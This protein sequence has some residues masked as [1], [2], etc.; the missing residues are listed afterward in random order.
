MMDSTSQRTVWGPS[1]SKFWTFKVKIRTFRKLVILYSQFTLCSPE[2]GPLSEHS[3]RTWPPCYEV[4]KCINEGVSVQWR[5]HFNVN[6][7]Y[8]QVD[9]DY[10]IPLHYTPP[11]LK[12]KWSK[13]SCSNPSKQGFILSNSFDRLVCHLLGHLLVGLV[14]LESRKQCKDCSVQFNTFIRQE[15]SQQNNILM[16]PN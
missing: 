10:A 3:S 12:F 7:T 13:I 8:G 5:C 15:V 1:S 14:D 4:S 2:F 16:F 11:A 9:I 6:C